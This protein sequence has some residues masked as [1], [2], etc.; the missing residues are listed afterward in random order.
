MCIPIY[1]YISICFA[2]MSFISWTL[3]LV[4]IAVKITPTPSMIA[5]INPPNNAFFKAIFRPPSL[6]A[7]PTSDCEKSS[8][9]DASCDCIQRIVFL[10]EVDQR[11]LATGEAPSPHCETS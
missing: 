10:A 8:R 6:L 1:R 4:W 2:C 9:E 11:A 7:I 5:R 3:F